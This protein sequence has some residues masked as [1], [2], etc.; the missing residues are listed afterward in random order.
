MN[1]ECI[2]ERLT[3]VLQSVLCPIAGC[4]SLHG[5]HSNYYFDSDAESYVLE[6]WPVGI[7]EPEEHEDNGNHRSDHSLLY[8]P[9]EFDFADLSK[10]VELEH[11]HFSQRRS[12]FEISWIEDGNHFELRVHIVPIEFDDET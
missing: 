1:E 7:E 12:L 6:V 5:G 11:F 2:K 10:H 4:W 9:A 8:E 3:E